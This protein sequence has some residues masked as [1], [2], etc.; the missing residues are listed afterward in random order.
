MVQPALPSLPTDRSGV[1]PSQ[2]LTAAIN[3]GVIDAGPFKIPLENVQPASLD[4]RLGEVAYRIRCSFLPDKQTVEDKVKDF[5]IDELDLHREGVV[6]ETNRPYLIPLKERLTLPDNVR[7]KT[8]P[9][10]STGWIDVFTRVITDESYRFDEI[11]SGY[12]GRGLQLLPPKSL[13]AD[14]VVA[15]PALQ[16]RRVSGIPQN[17]EG[18]VDVDDFGRV[19]GVPHVYAAGDITRFPVKQGGLAAQQADAAAEA[20]AVEAGARFEAQPFRPVLRGLL[21][22]GAEPRFLRRD[23]AA[24]SLGT[25]TSG[26]LWWPSTK[27]V[28]RRLSPFLAELSRE[29]PKQ[30]AA[31]IGLGF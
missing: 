16:G 28:G 5:I 29:A 22:T 26:P 27:I 3:A 9:K 6:L 2:H 23:V 19:R 15:L 14:A 8:N 4:L 24:G 21:L 17:R 10:S 25:E 13:E 7:G 11:A 18:F 12:D 1:L 31:P 30:S 20:I